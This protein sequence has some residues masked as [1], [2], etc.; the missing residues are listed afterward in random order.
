MDRIL[1]MI[2]IVVPLITV[3][4][5]V[6]GIILSAKTFSL[7][8]KEKAAQRKMAQSDRFA[9]AID[10]LKDES[11][12]IRMGALYELQRIGLEDPKEQVSIVRILSR[13]VRD[14]IED[15]K[16]LHPSRFYEEKV[17]PSEDVTLASEITS[18]FDAPTNW[19]QLHYLKADCVDL[20]IF[21]LQH[22]EFYDAQ[23][24]EA[25]F[26]HANLL[27]TIFRGANLKGADLRKAI[28]LTASQ[29][30]DAIVDDTTL[31]DPDLRAEY[32]RLKAERGG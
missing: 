9:R 3:T 18:L 12:H 1:S 32:D 28:N 4:V 15:R 31:L 13:Y 22:A 30:L 21:Q 26:P 8:A 19:L 17:R 2:Q 5:A 10:H 7:T 27:G 14:R 24:R 6:L 25:A 23:L 16:Y 29:L 20:G 11:I